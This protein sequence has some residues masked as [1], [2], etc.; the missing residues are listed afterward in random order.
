F[1]LGYHRQARAAEGAGEI[2]GR[3]VADALL[4]LVL[5]DE[6]APPVHVLPGFSDQAR[7]DVPCGH[8]CESL[9]HIW[10][11]PAAFPE[12]IA[13]AATPRASRTVPGIPA[14]AHA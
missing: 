3:V 6:R 1:H 4:E 2:L 14:A 12:S 9:A 5:R 8:S 7:Q 10:S 11:T 13:S